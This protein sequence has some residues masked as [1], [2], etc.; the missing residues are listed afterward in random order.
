MFVK[1]AAA[2]RPAG[3]A[4]AVLHLSDRGWERGLGPAQ[5]P[6]HQLQPDGGH[7]PLPHRLSGT[8]GGDTK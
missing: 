2:D 1:D 7:Q 3:L 6:R 8:H 4:A 5:G